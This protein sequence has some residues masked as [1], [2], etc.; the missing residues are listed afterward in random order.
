MTEL[1]TKTIAQL[2]DGFRA[3]DFSA[4]EIA[5]AFNEA[6][7]AGRALNA[8]TVETPE[9]AL[10]AVSSADRRPLGVPPIHSRIARSGR[11]RDGQRPTVTSS[12]PPLSG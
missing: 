2:R 4:R 1:T 8:W 10:D 11:E 12:A 5:T 9:L 7:V 3:G 6:V